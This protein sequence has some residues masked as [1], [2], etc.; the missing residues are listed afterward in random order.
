MPSTV[1]VKTTQPKWPKKATIRVGCL[2]PDQYHPPEPGTK[3][4][5]GITIKGLFETH[6][7]GLGNVPERSMI[8]A[9]FDELHEQIEAIALEQMQIDPLLGAERTAIKAAAMFRNRVAAGLQ[10]DLA[11]STI[12]SKERRGI[13]P[14]YKPL[15]ETGVL[16]SSIVGDAEVVL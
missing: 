3:Q 12:K 11:G 14:P 7:F 15:I 6:E 13:K 16:R 2:G 8:R 5:G 4:K 10:P 9:G 1:T